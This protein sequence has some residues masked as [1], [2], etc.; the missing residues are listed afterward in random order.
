MNRRDVLRAVAGTACVSTVAQ[1]A[2]WSRAETARTSG[3]GIVSL[4][5]GLQS[6]ISR[7]RDP[8][9]DLQEPLRCLE[10]CHRLGAGGIQVGLGVRDAGYT[11]TLRRQAEVYGMYIEAQATLPQT[12]AE[13]APFEAAVRTA[14]QCGARAVRVH[15]LPGRRYEFFDSMEKF[16]EYEKRGRRSIELAEPVMAR[17]RIPL[18]VENHKT[19]RI[20]E[21]VSLL[22]HVASPWV[23]VCL[24]TG[25]N[26]ALLED[27]LEVVHSLAPWT[28]AVHLKDQAVREY[29]EG[30]LMAD[31]P[32]GQG[33]LDLQ[34]MVDILRK[35]KPGMKF[36]LEMLTRDPLKIPCLT[37]KY[38]ASFVGVSGRNLA[39]TLRWVRK[40]AVP[41]LPSVANL[42]LAQQA[43]L[44][45]ANLRAC[46][47]FAREHLGL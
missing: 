28:V 27:P 5:H 43:T 45:E 4:S 21:F 42:P 12:E 40:Y 22:S 3:L 19:Y 47:T 16:A 15:T 46:L 1:F 23:G 14:A 6:Q 2:D 7:N 18:A 30:F 35:A 24:D 38:W 32:L 10:Y 29:E 11:A 39:R 9:A 13:V 37:D 26:L 34:A 33:C 20:A 17:H 41:R 25:N 36:S 31:V 8:K 44:E